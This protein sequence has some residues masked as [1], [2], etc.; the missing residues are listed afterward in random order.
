LKYR[1]TQHLEK[2]WGG[3]EEKIRY[4]IARETDNP[5]APWQHA[6]SGFKSY[7]AAEAFAKRHAQVLKETI[8][9]L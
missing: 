4:S 5:A 8:L 7:D 6:G 2:E 1:I 9:D 3:D